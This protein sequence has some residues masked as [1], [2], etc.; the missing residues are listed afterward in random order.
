MP[1][2]GKADS[3]EVVVAV[4]VNAYAAVLMDCQIQSRTASEPPKRS[5]GAKPVN[6]GR[7]SRALTQDLGH[8]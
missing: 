5:G 2:L 7:R 6:G 8:A 1:F 4:S 3:A